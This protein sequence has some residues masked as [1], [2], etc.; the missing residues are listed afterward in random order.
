MPAELQ[1]P[2]RE[3]RATLRARAFRP[4]PEAAATVV[5]MVL[6]AQVP[7]PLELAGVGVVVAGIAV[8]RSARAIMR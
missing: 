3:T 1:T 7:T 5:A 2:P 8:H 6:L 4:L